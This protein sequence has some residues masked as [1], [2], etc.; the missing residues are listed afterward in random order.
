MEEILNTISAELSRNDHDPS[1]ISVID[2]AYG[3]KKLAPETNKHC[4]FAVTGEYMNG[5]YQL[6]KG[7]YGPAD[8]QAMFR[9]K[10]VKTLGHRTPVW[11]D[12][13]IIVTRGTKEEHTRNLY[14]VLSKLENPQYLKMVSD[15][16]KKNGINEQVGAPSTKRT[17][18][19]FLGAIQYFAKFK[20]NLSEKTDK[21]IT[22]HMPQRTSK[23]LLVRLTA[24]E[25]A[26][27]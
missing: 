23:I 24:N 1:W 27:S 17:L 13:I 10:I 20:P 9:M 16:T 26:L 5:Y 2:L 22:I 12:D 25:N 6:P 3:Q 11:L 8:T 14:S 15:Q 4:K 19:P 18:K 7:F 21:I